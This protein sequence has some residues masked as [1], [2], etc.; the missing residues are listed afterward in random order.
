MGDHGKLFSIEA[1][2]TGR[3]SSVTPTPF[4]AKS[5]GPPKTARRH[6]SPMSKCGTPTSQVW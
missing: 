6:I 4:A 5:R 2:Y 1:G 3:T